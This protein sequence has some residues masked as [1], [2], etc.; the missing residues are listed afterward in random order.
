MN[1][2]TYEK[3]VAVLDPPFY[4]FTRTATSIYCDKLTAPKSTGFTKNRY[5]LSPGSCTCMSFMKGHDCKHLKML[6]GDFSWVGEGVSSSILVEE[7]DKFIE[8]CKES[9]PDSVEKWK[10]VT[11]TPMLVQ[12]VVLSIYEEIKATDVIMLCSIKKY[13]EIGSAAIVFKF[14]KKST[15][16]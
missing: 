8:I 2:S 13:P 16:T 14:E 10:T 3:I 4:V 1:R 12:S 11:D 7:I 6:R 9:F 15:G 5:L